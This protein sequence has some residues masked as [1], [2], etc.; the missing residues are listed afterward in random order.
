MEASPSSR[1]LLHSDNF[2]LPWWEL[3]NCQT[4]AITQN[5]RAT[6]G[7][8]YFQS[9]TP[10]V[11]PTRTGTE[12]AF[13]LVSTVFG[14]CQLLTLTPVDQRNKNI[15]MLEKAFQSG[16][17]RRGD[18][19]FRF[20][21]KT[22]CEA[23]EMD[24]ALVAKLE[25]HGD[26]R[27]A[28]SITF[29]SVHEGFLPN[30]C[31]NLAG[32]PCLLAYQ[33]LE[34]SF[35][36]A[37][38]QQTFP[39]D[40]DLVELGAQSY[41]GI[42]I[43][44]EKKEALGHLALLSRSPIT[45]PSHTERLFLR[46]F[47]S[48]SGAEFL[49]ESTEKKL[50]LSRRKAEEANQAKTRFLANMSHELRSPLNAVLGY[51]QLLAN[52][53]SLEE[54]DRQRVADI[55]RNGRHLLFLINDILDM[56]RIELSHIEVNLTTF[57]LAE[58]H[59]DL[60]TMFRPETVRQECEFVLRIPSDLPKHILSDRVK[61]RQILTNLISN[62]L[63]YGDKRLITYEV[64]R[65]TA[66]E[67][68]EPH[69]LFHVANSGE[70]LT[71]ESRERVFLPFER[72]DD[73]NQGE[74]PVDGTGLGLSIARSFARRMGG[75]LFHKPL[76][77]GEFRGNLFTL[78]IPLILPTEQQLEET[79]PSSIPPNH[80]LSGVVLV[81]DDNEASRDIVRQL[82]TSKGLIVLE[83][84]DGQEGIDLCLSQR[85]DLVLMDVRM[86]KMSGLEA[87]SLLKNKLAAECP[88]IVG[89]TGDLLDVQGT[90][91]KHELFDLVIGKPFNF[92][93]LIDTVHTFLQS[94]PE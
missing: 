49:R 41:L 29:Y 13:K 56:S 68:H 62:A 88:P 82:L 80:E 3:L 43:L 30:L 92:E 55:N 15:Q 76:S 16:E 66:G 78:K 37:N 31:Y 75:D 74:T 50:R 21:A 27:I 83:A 9:Q 17:F 46:I 14:D 5:I 35:V 69:L 59:K 44:G 64:A 81:V 7:E 52:S 33:S 18:D 67:G 87:S 11:I 23:M 93:T 71:K 4:P 40:P 63:K 19:Y 86:P 38:L 77:T 85:P 26:Q 39:D 10:L 72:G 91:M 58:I 8:N 73:V 51:S 42:S 6:R 79:A 36:P 1:E 24:Y 28:R 54:E 2:Q 25:R 57:E 48:R 89:F 61:L 60:E 32:T 94:D 47:A 53:K 70:P 84:A 90:P 65:E 45:P 20:W 34:P 22:F 12:K